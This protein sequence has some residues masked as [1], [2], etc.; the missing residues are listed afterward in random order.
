MAGIENTKLIQAI[1]HRKGRYLSLCKSRKCWFFSDS[2]SVAVADIL[3]ISRKSAS[4]A[5][6]FGSNGSLNFFS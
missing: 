6:G 4:S 1:I 5:I 3:V 2:M